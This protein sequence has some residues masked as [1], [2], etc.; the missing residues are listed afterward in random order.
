MQKDHQDAW[1]KLFVLAF[2]AILIGTV[3]LQV[4]GKLRCF[5]QRTKHMHFDGHARALRS[6]PAR[7]SRVVREETCV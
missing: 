7:L 2:V 4:S 6:M 3:S 5:L 1:K